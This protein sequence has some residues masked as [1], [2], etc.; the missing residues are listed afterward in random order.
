MFINSAEEMHDVGTNDNLL[1]ASQFVKMVEEIQGLK[2]GCPEEIAWRMGYISNQ[3]LE[4]LIS[5]YKEVDYANY[6]K[7]ILK[8]A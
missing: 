8:D 5:E 2:I 4:R 1:K 6:L 7:S 3:D